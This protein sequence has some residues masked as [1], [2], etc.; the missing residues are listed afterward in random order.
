MSLAGGL[1][2]SASS[3]A[4]AAALARAGTL[5]DPV[6]GM[7]SVIASLASTLVDLPV[8]A[9]VAHERPLTRKTALAL[10][11]ITVVGTAGV[12]VGV[13]TVTLEP[14]LPWIESFRQTIER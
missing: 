9:R 4:S 7:G 5:S 12:V 14:F 8:V 3:V 1:V 13:F 10:G 2:S 6:A 11:L